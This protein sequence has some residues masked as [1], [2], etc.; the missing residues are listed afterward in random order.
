M[1]KCKSYFAAHLLFWYYVK[2]SR[3][4]RV[5]LIAKCDFG[6]TMPRPLICTNIKN[7]E[8]FFG[9]SSKSDNLSKICQAYAL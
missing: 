9:S 6:R 7:S 3:L 1:E 4:K 2:F 5:G 8:H